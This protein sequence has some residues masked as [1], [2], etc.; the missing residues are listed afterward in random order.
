M[1]AHGISQVT[2]YIDEM[3]R[4]TMLDRASQITCPTLVIECEGDFVGGGGQALVDAITRVRPPFVRLTVNR[5]R[6]RLI[7]LISGSGS[8]KPRS[9]TGSTASLPRERPHRSAA[10]VKRD[11]QRVGVGQETM[12]RGTWPH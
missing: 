4:Y 3:R 8:G 10:A 1:A 7:A 5:R 12:A 9:T 6:Q 2:D 11:F